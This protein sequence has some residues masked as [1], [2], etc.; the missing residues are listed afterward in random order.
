MSGQGIATYSASEWLDRNGIQQRHRF[1]VF[2]SLRS[3]LDALGIASPLASIFSINRAVAPQ[4]NRFLAIIPRISR[5]TMS[6]TWTLETNIRALLATMIS[7]MSHQSL[8][9]DGQQLVV[10]RPM[11]YGTACL[12]PK[13][14]C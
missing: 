4:A 8:P 1:S 2:R 13:T 12:A 9:C 14:E 5:Y 3:L 11:S 7:S 10:V 6:Q